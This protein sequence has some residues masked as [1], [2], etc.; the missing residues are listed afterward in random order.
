METIA[1]SSW[2]GAPSALERRRTA[3]LGVSWRWSIVVL[4]G[5]HHGAAGSPWVTAS[6]AGS[7]SP[8]WPWVSRQVCRKPAAQPPSPTHLRLSERP[9]AGAPDHKNIGAL[10]KASS[11]ILTIAP[12]LTHHDE[13]PAP[14]GPCFTT[15][16]DPTAPLVRQREPRCLPPLSDPELNALHRL[17]TLAFPR[18]RGS[19]TPWSIRPQRVRPIPPRSSP[20]SACRSCSGRTTALCPRTR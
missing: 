9:L 10:P 5:R 20:S 8:G 7:S 15:A 16:G 1:R 11:Y 4:A 19:D 17:G 12:T 6:R 2:R 13:S 18:F 14:R 3:V